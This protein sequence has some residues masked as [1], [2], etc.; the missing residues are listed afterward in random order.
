[1]KKIEFKEWEA[2]SDFAYC[3]GKLHLIVDGEEW[4]SEGLGCLNHSFGC[5]IGDG[6]HEFF[7]K[8]VWGLN[9]G[10]FKDFSEDE[11]KVILDLVNKNMEAHCCGGCL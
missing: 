3:S 5:G 7:I 4:I 1:M 11:K 9:D 6:G 2:Y 10:F 8:G